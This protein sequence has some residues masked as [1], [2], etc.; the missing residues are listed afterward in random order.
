MRRPLFSPTVARV[1]LAVLLFGGAYF[2]VRPWTDCAFALPSAS[3]LP[4]ICAFGTS[5]PGFVT[6]LW[7]NLLAAA[8]YVVAGL[9]IALV[10]RVELTMPRRS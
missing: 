9:A 7:P 3:D 8:I 1:A 5:I 6:P 4:G 10:G 2:A